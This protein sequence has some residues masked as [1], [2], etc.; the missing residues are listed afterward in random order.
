MRSFALFFLSVMIVACSKPAG[1]NVADE[2][3][4][5]IIEENSS[6]EIAE[7]PEEKEPEATAKAGIYQQSRM[8]LDSLS[9]GFI[10]EGETSPDVETELLAEEFEPGS[11]VVM[12]NGEEIP[13][14]W[15]SPGEILWSSNNRYAVLHNEDYYADRGSL[16]LAIVDI[17]SKTHFSISCSE[18]VNVEL[19]GRNGFQIHDISWPDPDRFTFGLK[20]NYLGESGHPGIDS[21]LRAEMGDKFGVDDPIQVGYYAVSVGMEEE[22]NNNGSGGSAEFSETITMLLATAYIDDDFRSDELAESWTAFYRDENGN[23]MAKD[24]ELTIEMIPGIFDEGDSVPTVSVEGEP[25]FLLSGVN[26]SESQQFQG[27]DLK[28]QLLP[29]EVIQL[30]KYSL[31]ATG[32]MQHNNPFMVS[33]YGL[34]LQGPKNG[35]TLGDNFLTVEWFDD[36][37]VKLYWAGDLD[38]DG[39]PDLFL[40]KSHKYSFSNPALFLSSRAAGNKLLK[41]EAETRIMGD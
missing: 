36:A 31:S 23:I 26:V 30:G 41:L 28:Q 24:V 21:N 22:A 20:A 19:E 13:E 9:L 37:M 35:S 5:L 4:S 25:M 10:H 29:G 33:D 14:L 8:V 38:G 6:T 15:V 16:D 32:K 18:L 39:I 3:D 34:H 7:I 17:I 12:V 1:N 27:Y 40:D 11:Y 2:A